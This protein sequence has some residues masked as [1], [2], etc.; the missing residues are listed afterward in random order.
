MLKERAMG[1]AKRG[2]KRRITL[3]VDSKIYD[4]Y[5]DYCGKNGIILSKRVEMFMKGEL[6]KISKEKKGEDSGA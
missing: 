3:S 6:E 5:R 1:T 4:R 2:L